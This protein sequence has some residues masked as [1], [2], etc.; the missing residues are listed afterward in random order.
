MKLTKSMAKM[1]QIDVTNIDQLRTYEKNGYDVSEWL[2]AALEKA[3][4]RDAAQDVREGKAQAGEVKLENPIDLEKLTP[5]LA[6]PRD[7]GSPFVADMMGLGGLFGKEKR[8][9]ALSEAPLVFGAVVQANHALW[10][11]GNNTTTAVFVIAKDAAHKNDAAWL[12]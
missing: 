8:A 1:Y 4:M 2:P 3:K 11:P 5:Y 12:N 9:R 7:A 10:K 6:A